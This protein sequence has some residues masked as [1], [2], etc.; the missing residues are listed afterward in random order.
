M[1]KIPVQDALYILRANY[2]MVGPLSANTTELHSFESAFGSAVAVN[3]FDIFKFLPP[4][5]IVN[6][7]QVEKLIATTPE[8]LYGRLRLLCAIADFFIDYSRKSM[9]R[10]IATGPKHIREKL[11]EVE[12]LLSD[13]S[14]RGELYYSDCPRHPGFAAASGF[15]AKY[16]LDEVDWQLATFW[17]GYAE[18]IKLIK[19]RLVPIEPFDP[20]DL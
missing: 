5:L 9:K 2:R 4:L 3:N 10:P 1:M 19:Q 6:D 14:M 13:H 17:A 20:F 16:G 15:F 8:N 7:W 11:G 18:T 12:G